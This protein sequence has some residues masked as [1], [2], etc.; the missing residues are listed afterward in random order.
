MFPENIAGKLL[1]GSIKGNKINGLL[2]IKVKKQH[3]KSPTWGVGKG[4]VSSRTKGNQS[5]RS[6]EVKQKTDRS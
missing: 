1:N 4:L 5:G 6:T 2:Y 3:V